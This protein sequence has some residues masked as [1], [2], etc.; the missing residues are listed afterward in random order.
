MAGVQGPVAQE[1]RIGD[2]P[3]RVA[4]YPWFHTISPLIS[5]SN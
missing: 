5:A 2:H 4:G 1:T 3:T